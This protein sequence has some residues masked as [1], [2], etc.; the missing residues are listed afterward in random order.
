MQRSRLYLLYILYY[1]S[2]DALEAVLTIVL[3][4]YSRSKREMPKNMEVLTRSGGWCP[5]YTEY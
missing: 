4:Q 2:R 3:G 5:D 1:T